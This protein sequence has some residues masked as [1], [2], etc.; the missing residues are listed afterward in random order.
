MKAEL[1]DGWTHGRYA[2]RVELIV[3]VQLVHR[4]M[5][6]AHAAALGQHAVVQQ[7]VA[8]RQSVLQMGTA[9]GLCSNN[10]RVYKNQSIRI[11]KEHSTHES[12]NAVMMNATIL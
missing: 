8:L 2:H 9:P 1:S 11:I 7:R 4:C 12:I 6:R 10:Q 3:C 5:K